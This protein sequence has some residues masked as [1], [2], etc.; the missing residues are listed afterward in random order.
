MIGVDLTEA[1]VAEA[2]GPLDRYACKCHEASLALVLSGILP[3][4]GWRVARGSC[5]GV[6][7]QHSW[8]VQGDP[9][10][11]GQVVDLTAWSYDAKRPRVW[12]PK[13]LT[14]HKPHGLGSIWQWGQPTVGRG[15]LIPLA[16][17]L[18]GAAAA[19]IKMLFPNGSDRQGWAQLAHAPV[20]GWPAKA[21]I[22]AILDTPDLDAL[23]PVDIVGMLTDRNPGNL[24]F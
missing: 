18:D 13:N 8:A 17:P 12:M 2:I 14:V 24:Y 23:V 19:F 11:R 16:V 15:P 22:E 1:A 21:I 4:E 6:G 5:R 9:Y 3:G 7:G 10:E 20:E